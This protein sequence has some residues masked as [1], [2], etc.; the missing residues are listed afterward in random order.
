LPNLVK[1]SSSLA[2]AALSFTSS[3]TALTWSTTDFLFVFGDS[4]TTT[5]FNISAGV[6]SVDPGW[7][8]SNG[9]NWVQYLKNTFNIATPQVFNL[10]V[11][12]AV[13]DNKLVTPYKAGLASLVDQ[14]SQFATIL[15]PKPAGAQWS[16]DNSL[17]A[18]WIGINDV[19]NSW[20]WTNVTQAAF[21][22]T[23]MDHYFSAVETL[24]DSGARSFLF[25]TVPPIDRAP[26]FIEQGTS[27]TAAV[28]LS[29]ADYNKKL[30]QRVKKFQSAHSDL[31]QITV[32]DTSNIFN[33]L[34]NMGDKLGFVNTTG[35]SE[36]YEN[37][38][39]QTTTQIP[40]Y[41][42]VS[43]FFWLNSLHP[44]FT[45]HY[46]LAHAISTAISAL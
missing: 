10:A 21:H 38:T 29:L 28:K 43:S 42:P 16:S 1:L 13:T 6:N 46:S 31:G 33:T 15:G 25:L 30:A 14:A 27:S 35:Y 7:T 5:G 37:G 24:Y 45:V 18:I 26:L 8:A 23:V 44:V 32:F 9:Q 4:Y 2:T 3:A 19:G 36:L 12:G 20:Y 41:A 40:P 17:F 34:L 39:P 22:D 11:G